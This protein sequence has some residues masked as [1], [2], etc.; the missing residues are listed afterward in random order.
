MNILDYPKFIRP[1][2]S[3]IIAIISFFTSTIGGGPLIPHGK[4]IDMTKYEITWQDEF[5][6]E[7]LDFTKWNGH[8]FSRG[9]TIA[10][11]GSYWN[12]DLASVKDGKLHIAT[13]YYPEGLN[14]NEKPGWYTCGIDTSRSVMQRYGYF[15]CRCIL[16]KGVGLWSAFWM[17]AN[18]VGDEEHF[19]TNG[20]YG[21]E[22]DIFESAYYFN[23]S[24]FVRNSVS[25]NIHIDG[26]EEFHKQTNVCNVHI[27][28]NPYEEFNTYGVRWTPEEY[29]FYINGI[30][31]GRTKFGVSQV[32]EWLIL[33]VEVGGEDAVASESWAGPDINTNT[34]PI[35]DFV[36][37]YVRM[38]KEK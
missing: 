23:D 36:V 8:F 26:Y 21:S 3:I 28:N 7:A 22:I 34:E 33:S 38:Y 37:D 27:P 19:G 9:D 12:I 6:G 1:V 17:F 10:R 29:I 15:E 30:E 31:T 32:P 20:K 2:I 35:T 14:G 18:G 11:K 24:E 16:P 5:D 13:R 25:T 4:E